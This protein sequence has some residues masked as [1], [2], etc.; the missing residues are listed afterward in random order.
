MSRPVSVTENLS[1]APYRLT[2]GAPLSEA[3]AAQLLTR[4][5]LGE[6]LNFA[7]VK[8]GHLW[9]LAHVATLNAAQR[10]EHARRVS[11]AAQLLAG[12]SV[13]AQICA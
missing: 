3:Q 6:A 5:A 11:L 8:A 4:A 13:P 1:A 7:P 2:H 10:T 9:T 12:H